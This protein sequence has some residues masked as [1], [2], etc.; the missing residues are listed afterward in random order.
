MI[1]EVF[2]FLEAFFSP[3]MRGWGKKC[4]KT[5]GFVRDMTYL[6]ATKGGS[7]AENW[8]PLLVLLK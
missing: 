8:K 7:D 4:R 3:N 6:Q 5:G 2:V 1:L